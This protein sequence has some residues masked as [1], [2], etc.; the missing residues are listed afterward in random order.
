MGIEGIA[1]CNLYLS[2]RWRWVVGFTYQPLC[3]PRKSP[4]YPQ[5]TMDRRLDGPQSHSERDCWEL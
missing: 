5:Y 2:I 3:F 1:P 4:Q